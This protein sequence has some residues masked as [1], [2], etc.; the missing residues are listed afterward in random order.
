MKF[1]LTLLS[2]FFILG[3]VGAQSAFQ[4][5]YGQLATGYENNSV[6][7][8]SLTMNNNSNFP[9]GN[10]PSKGS[11]PLIFGAGY[12]FGINNQYLIGIGV[13][14]SFF[15]TNIGNSWI[16]GPNS[17]EVN[18]KVSNRFNLFLAPGYAIT[19]ESL[20]YAKAGYSMQTIKAEYTNGAD[21]ANGSSMG[22]SNSNGYVLGLGYKQMVQKSFYL[23]TEANYYNYA[24]T[25][26]NSTL[27]DTTVITNF[28]PTASAYNF[29]IGV[30]YKF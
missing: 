5:F 10:N 15:E 1:L 29:L 4:G 18:Y 19:R 20:V 8:T 23:F 6:A 11:M 30:G 21:T 16:N 24:K 22:S 26:L 25:T 9:G 2:S 13:D 17:G 28:S 27:R 12:N 3:G 7:N 14:Y